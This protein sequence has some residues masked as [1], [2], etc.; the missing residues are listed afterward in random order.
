[1]LKFEKILVVIF[2]QIVLFTF[3]NV[4]SDGLT[5]LLFPPLFS[6]TIFFSLLFFFDEPIGR[7]EAWFAVFL[8][9]VAI[10]STGVGAHL[11][12][13]AIHNFFNQELR[14]IEEPL[15]QAVNFSE[16]G[17]PGFLYHYDEWT[18]HVIIFIGVVLL[19]I[20]VFLLT[21]DYFKKT[22]TLFDNFSK[23]VNEIKPSIN[24]DRI[25]LKDYVIVSFIAS[26]IGVL[27]S[28][29]GIE[30]NVVYYGAILSLL[31]LSFIGAKLRKALSMN[32]IDLKVMFFLV[33]LASYLATTIAYLFVTG[34]GA[35]SSFTF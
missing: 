9:S 16:T 10:M 28:L 25:T 33:F 6:V 22:L 3:L 17:I 34:I 32:I 21:R 19:A 14:W 35:L 2:L 7:N 31:A 30:G 26:F 15:E 12:A 29:M 18:S 24:V 8:A 1:M 5:A 4:V 27:L 20:S 23:K 13:N 11:T